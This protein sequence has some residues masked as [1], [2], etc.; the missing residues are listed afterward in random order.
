MLHLPWCLI[1]VTF[2]GLHFP[3][4]H[5]E[6][7]GCC[8]KGIH[9]KNWKSEFRKWPTVLTLWVHCCLDFDPDPHDTHLCFSAS[10][11]IRHALKQ[12]ITKTGGPKSS[13]IMG[14]C[15][16]ES[17]MVSFCHPRISHVGCPKD[18]L[19]FISKGLL[20][21]YCCVA[22]NQ[23]LQAATWGFRPQMCHLRIKG[24]SHAERSA[25]ANNECDEA[26]F[27][28]NPAEIQ[29]LCD[30]SEC[31]M[32]MAFQ[33]KDLMVWWFKFTTKPTHLAMLPKGSELHPGLQGW[34]LLLHLSTTFHAVSRWLKLTGEQFPGSQLNNMWGWKWHILV[35]GI[36][37]RVFP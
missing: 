7:D 29:P 11:K 17:L 34:N 5:H 3:R 21:P 8:S 20:C 16:I 35:D 4:V 36:G 28:E 18:W 14:S 27:L 32:G 31:Q 30:F 2:D 13:L 12:Q 10:S 1:L 33:P 23:P 24:R 37:H 22:H 26:A 25:P 19:V 6:G 9:P 15:S